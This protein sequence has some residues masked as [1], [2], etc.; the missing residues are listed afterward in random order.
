MCSE[1]GVDGGGAEQKEGNGQAHQEMVDET[2]GEWMTFKMRKGA[3]HPDLSRQ[4]L[5]PHASACDCQIC[6]TLRNMCVGLT[7]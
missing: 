1:V 4:A 2:C 7:N 5:E 6:A 3:T